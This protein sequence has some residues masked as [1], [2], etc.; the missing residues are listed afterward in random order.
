MFDLLL[1][2]FSHGASQKVI[3]EQINHALGQRARIAWWNEAPGHA[4][5]HDLRRTPDSGSDDWHARCHRLQ[6]DHG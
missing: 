4:I 2:S 1:A 6:H 3:S 5:L